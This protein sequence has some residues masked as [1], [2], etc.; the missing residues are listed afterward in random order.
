[1]SRSA[2][3]VLMG[4]LLLASADGWAL[5][6][7]DQE[8]TRRVERLE[9]RLGGSNQSDLVYQ[10]ERLQQE[11]QQLRGEL[12]IQQHALDAMHR[13]QQDLYKDLDQRLGGGASNGAVSPPTDPTQAF[14]PRPEP[15]GDNGAGNQ[16][17]SWAPPKPSG[18]V[19]QSKQA[20]PH[21]EAAYKT[22]FDQLKSGQYNKSIESFRGFIT[23]YPTGTYAD[24]AQYWLGEAYYVQRDYDAALSEFDKVIRLYPHSNKVADALLKMG[25]IQSDKEN[26][27]QANILLNRLVKEYPGT[28]SASLGGKQLD[29][30][31]SQGH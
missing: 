20:D 17:P 11:I 1:M 30:L 23:A 31:R 12:E 16:A 29:R 5:F 14:L 4:G 9:Q 3:L 21:Q 7:S 22:A 10:V 28:T 2:S 27:R 18:P 6:G 8:L 13:R 19:V 15:A 26:W 24:N 25:Y